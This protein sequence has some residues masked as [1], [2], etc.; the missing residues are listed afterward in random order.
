MHS[1]IGYFA[2]W[3]PAD[4]IQVGDIGVFETGRFRKLASLR[5]FGIDSTTQRAGKPQTLSYSSTEATTVASSGSASAIGVARAEIAIKFSRQGAFTFQAMGVQNISLTSRSA[6]AA[7]II[8]AFERR[9][10]KSNW[11]VVDSVYTADSATIIVSEDQSADITLSGSSD[12]PIT[13]MSLADPKIGLTVSAIRGKLVYVVAAGGLR[14][15]Y[16][17]LRLRDPLFGRPSVEAVRGS[18]TDHNAAQA[19]ARPDV[20]ELLES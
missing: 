2:T 12:L 18:A 9:D 7:S 16:S 10:W 3:L 15:L 5:E 20:S 1:N 19:L 14:P 17:C 8:N 4:A 11:L 13:P 6:A